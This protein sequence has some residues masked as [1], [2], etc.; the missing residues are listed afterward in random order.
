[1]L[2]RP[3]AAAWLRF[4]EATFSDPTLTLG[5]RSSALGVAF[6]RGRVVAWFARQRPAPPP[7]APPAPELVE[8][9]RAR[10]ELAQAAQNQRNATNAAA[11]LVRLR[12]LTRAEAA[13]SQGSP[14]LIA[15]SGPGRRL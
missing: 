2:P 9:R 6:C 5:V 12:E 10:R 7:P 1:M 14:E 15:G 13:P 11:A 4:C 3:N 8:A